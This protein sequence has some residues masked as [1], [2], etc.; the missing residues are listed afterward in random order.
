MEN[1][2]LALLSAN[3][4]DASAPILK[5][6]YLE[7]KTLLYEPGGMVNAVDFPTTAVVSLVVGLS[8]GEGVEAAMIGRDGA[9]GAASALDG[10]ISLTQAIVQLGGDAW[11]CH[12][13]QLKE[14]ALQRHGILSALIRNEQLVYAQAQQSTAC[15][16]AH[17]VEARFCRWLLRARD[18]ADSKM[19]PF[20]QQ[21]LA[22]MLGVQRSSVTLVAH[23]L[24]RAGFI[25]YSR[26]KIQIWIGGV[27]RRFVRML[28]RRE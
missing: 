14:L 1:H 25:K 28:R 19:L 7:Q 11:T 21:F 20:T 13:D 16:A 27:E 24:Q 9:V 8:R 10:K 2:L 6:I 4:A 3:D 22:E 23:T 15:I 18:L 5:R 26:G 12:P 17:N